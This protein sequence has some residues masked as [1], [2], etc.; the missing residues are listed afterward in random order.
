M[1]F[2]LGAHGVWIIFST[3]ITLIIFYQ[4]VLILHVLLQAQLVILLLLRVYLN[5]IFHFLE[6]LTG[7][8]IDLRAMAACSYSILSASLAS[9]DADFSW[10]SFTFEHA[11]I[12]DLQLFLLLLLPRRGFP[13]LDNTVGLL[14]VWW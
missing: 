1:H 13:A 9:V 11:L 4:T 10:T 3:H 2:G 8:L 7:F 6:P 12:F 14:L 5:C